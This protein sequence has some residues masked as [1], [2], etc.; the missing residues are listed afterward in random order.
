[1]TA[2]HIVVEDGVAIITF[3]LPGEPVNK[4][5]ASVIAEMTALLDR[6]NVICAKSAAND[7]SKILSA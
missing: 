2:L 4:F 6:S 3:D 1:M 5:T 7:F